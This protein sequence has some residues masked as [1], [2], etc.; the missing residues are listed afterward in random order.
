MKKNFSVNKIYL[1]IGTAFAATSLCFHAIIFAYTDNRMIRGA[2][3]LFSFLTLLIGL[4]L[5]LLLRRKLITFSEVL[6]SCIDD[7]LDGKK[8]VQFDLESETLTGKFNYKLKRLYEVLNNNKKN[9]KLEKQALQEI[10]SDIS[11]QVKTPMTNLKMYNSTLIERQLLPDKQHEFHKLM[12]TQIDKLDFLMQAMI[13]I[14]RL[15]TGIISLS[16]KSALL[17]D[18]IGLALGGIVLPSEKKNITVNVECNPALIVPHD[19][20][21]TAEALFNILDNAVKY[22]PQGGKITILAKRW[23]MIT[24]I[25]ISDTGKGIPE[26]HLAQIFKRFYREEDVHDIEGVGIGLYLCREIISKQGGY[27]QVQSEIGRG[28]IFSIFF[29]NERQL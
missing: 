13:K 18:T 16:I 3:L 9:I 29:L 19:K 4:V 26:Q 6:N 8:E 17:Y 1:G 12:K 7:I 14:S 27:I 21:W 11:H 15:E 24:R 23:E 22:T 10:I 2:V 5:I 25:D 28:S 20:K